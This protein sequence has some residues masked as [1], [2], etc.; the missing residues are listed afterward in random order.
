MPHELDE[1]EHKTG[2]VRGLVQIEAKL[3]ILQC[4]NALTLLRSRLHTK[5]HFLHFNNSNIAG[6][7]GKTKAQTLGDEIGER[8]TASAER[9]RKG[10]LALCRL[11]GDAMDEQFWVLKEEDIQLD[12]DYGESDE[13]AKKKLAMIGSGWGARV[14]RNA[15]GTSKRVMSWIWTAQGGA[16]DGEE[17]LHECK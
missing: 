2:C 1:A 10:R 3:C 11:Q 12:G 9:Y 17:H 13:A 15:L 16:T 14:P 5:R 4:L 8:V 6:Q 7:R